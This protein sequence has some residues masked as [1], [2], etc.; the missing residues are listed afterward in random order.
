MMAADLLPALDP[1]GLPGPPWLFQALLLLT[2]FFHLMFMNLTLGGTLLAAVAHSLSRGRTDDPRAV[3]ARRVV[4]VN[5]VGISL[6]ITTGVA[7]LLFMQLLY[8]Q[9]FYTATILIGWAWFSLVVL[10]AFGYYAVYAYKLRRSPIGGGIWLWLSAT[11][12]LV[13]A[14]LQ[15][16]VHLVQVQPVSWPQLT[17]SAWS[18]LTDPAFVPRWLHF[19][20]AGLGASALLHA[21]WAVRQTAHGNDAERNAAVAGFAWRWAMWS[22]AALV[23]D[24][25]V[26]LA[27][28]PEGVVLGLM[29]G[30]AA[31]MVPLSLA[32]G[33]G[34][35]VLVVVARCIDPTARQGAVTAAATAMCAAVAAM[36]VTRS[37]VR[38]LYLGDAI[39]LSAVHVAPQWGNFVLFAVVLVAGLATVYLMVRKVLDEPASGDEAA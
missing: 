15:V 18:V 34:V 13:I 23:V 39:D 36:T 21:W 11:L 31:T 28:L 29:R 14:A 6:T 26:L 8:Q 19:V 27:V 20:L 16:A 1:A 10:L 9:L 37:Q 5:G 33:L 25:F 30:G 2:F 17:G 24:G 35:V 7:P 38:A 22:T 12:F 3:L 32:I 4:A